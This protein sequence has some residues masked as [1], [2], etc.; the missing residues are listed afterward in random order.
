MMTILQWRKL[1]KDGKTLAGRRYVDKT[2]IRKKDLARKIIASKDCIQ[3]E[4]YHK[5][6]EELDMHVSQIWQRQKNKDKEFRKEAVDQ[7]QEVGEN[8]DYEEE[9]ADEE[10]GFLKWMAS[11]K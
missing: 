3:I 5:E 4:E 2:R 8:E 9:E 1:H 10:G 6:G 7:E 11:E